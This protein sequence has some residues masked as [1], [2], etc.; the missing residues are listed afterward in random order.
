MRKELFVFKKHEVYNHA[1]MLLPKSPHTLMQSEI[2]PRILEATA[3]I[4]ILILMIR[5]Q[6]PLGFCIKNDEKSE[7]FLTNG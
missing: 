6:I 2:H 7:S 4:L 1:L 3:L 5:R